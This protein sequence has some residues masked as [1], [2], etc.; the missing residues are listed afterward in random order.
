[1]ATCRSSSSSSSFKAVK[2]HSHTNLKLG[3][4]SLQQSS[5]HSSKLH[6]DNLS[7]FNSSKKKK[8]S[9]SGA[10]TGSHN[11][12]S[13]NTGG[14]QDKT[15][16]NMF[17]G[18]S[19][20][21]G[22]SQ[23]DFSIMEYCDRLKKEFNVL[24]Q[25]CQSLKFD[26]EK[27]AQEKIEVH[28]QYVMYYEMSYGLNVE[29]HR[30][31]ELAKRYLAI[32]HQIIPCLSQEQQNQVAATLE[33]AKQVTV[34]ELNAIIGQQMHGQGATFPHGH[35]SSPHLAALTAAH[36]ASPYGLPGA[37]GLPPGLLAL[38]GAAAAAQQAFLKDEKDNL[39]RAE[40]AAAAVAAAAVAASSHKRSSHSPHH[41]TDKYRGHS[42]SPLESHE[43]KKL[44]RDEESDGDKSDGDLVVD[45]ANDS[46]KQIMNGSRSPL[47]NGDA[48]KLN[49]ASRHKHSHNDDSSRSPHSDN[50]SSRST[51]SQKG[52]E[53]SGS[54]PITAAAT[55]TSS[56]GSGGNSMNKTSSRSS[57]NSGVRHS[58]KLPPAA[59]FGPYGAF[60]PE[61]FAAFAAG[62][63]PASVLNA[64][65]GGSLTG[66]SSTNL[67]AV[68]NFAARPLL[69]SASLNDLYSAMRIPQQQQQQQQLQLSNPLLA[70][71]SASAVASGNITER[72]GTKIHYSFHC[73]S[74]DPSPSSLQPY[75]FPSDA[76]DSLG[77]PRR[78]R[79]LSTLI[80]GD[81][82]CAVTIADQNKHI[83]TGGKGCVKVWDLKESIYNNTNANGRSS[84]LTISKPIGQFE[85]LSRDAYIRSVKLLPDGR[86]LIVGG[87]AS[88]ISIWDL[89]LTPSTPN[90][91]ALGR[92]GS[93][94][95][96]S[97]SSNC[98]TNSP[99][100]K[101]KG[102]LQSKAAACYALA[103]STDGKLCFSC[104]SD[105]NVLVWDIHNHAIVRQ[106][107]GHTDGASCID[108]T[109][110]GLRVW[111]GGL[112]NSV[113]CWDVREGRQLQQ[114]EFDSQ[115]FSLGYCPTGGDWLA[116]GMEQSLI[117][118]LNVSS[119]KPDKYRL[120][121]HESC[122]LALKFARS[123]RWFLSTSKDNQL[124][125]WKTPYGA[126]LFENKECSSVLSCDISQDDN[127]IVTGSGDKKATLYEV[128]YE[129]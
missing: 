90:G 120:T 113:R 109:P 27:L 107:Q 44:K 43:S 25:Q 57:S 110:D 123:G 87:E 31:S 83:Y 16:S 60:I 108:L 71:T 9:S 65:F 22:G 115:I 33:R 19:G 92:D 32:C 13:S 7:N 119:S 62:L 5:I 45:D 82:V 54:G 128:I 89:N 103:I 46:D 48:S 10:V 67:N 96:S 56:S 49:L 20:P 64:A 125:G 91:S 124:T 17:P 15:S 79:I 68:N 75:T 18:R 94:S 12:G 114:F 73:D 23:V 78:T 28:R 50:G 30:Q 81:V 63:N 34:A 117:D 8:K 80:H 127:F 26:C 4:S 51:P 106:F 38:Q 111:T 59:M 6:D 52:S 95:N 85:C 61:N 72:N 3:S 74:F 24:Q 93:N 41:M 97:T 76:F 116:V 55:N 39:E 86:T 1:M 105:G 53:K 42:R 118:I 58:P 98:S 101:P 37:G 77:C 126:K 69:P 129:R 29:M 84:P 14:G 36:A 21:Q 2:I 121:Q 66:N 11:T 100:I 104:C 99:V 112:D 70:I 88:N 35:N 122:I 40:K 102:E 47:E